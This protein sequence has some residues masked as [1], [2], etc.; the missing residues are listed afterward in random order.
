M[1]N[2]NLTSKLLAEGIGTFA[3][4]LFLVGALMSGG[5]IA[6]FAPAILGLTVMVMVYSFGPISG[7]HFNPAITLAVC[8]TCKGCYKEMAFYWIAQIIGAVCA[9][10]VLKFLM[11]T[12]TTLGLTMPAATLADSTAVI[13][14]AI[15][16]FFVC[17][18]AIVMLGEKSNNSFAGLAIGTALMIGMIFAAPA[19]GS[20]NPARSI[21]PALVAGET[22]KL[23]IYIAGPFLGA[24]AAGFVH[25][26]LSTGE[27]GK[28]S[29]STSR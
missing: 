26:Q 10:Y 16:T 18:T 17:F 15:A 19:G 8:M 2:N 7:G 13:W 11:P 3:L 28:G 21:G 27:W 12:A 20:L 1:S 9:V 29:C 22:M 14:E 25:R 24:I 5:S 4:V 23:W 6:A